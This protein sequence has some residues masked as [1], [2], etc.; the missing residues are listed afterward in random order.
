MIDIR[1]IRQSEGEAFLRHLCEVFRLDFNRAYDV[2]FT[3]PFFD[4]ARKWALFD[5]P[6]IISCLTTTPLE[7]GW[8]R[9]CGIAGVAT[10]ED[11]R[12]EGLAQLLLE[13]VLKESELHGEGSVLLFAHSTSVYE[14][15]GFEAIDRVIRAELKTGRE[16]IPK[17]LPD[18]QIEAKYNAW[19][20]AHPDRLRRDAR[21]WE[22]WHWNGREASPF[23]EGYL[24]SEAGLLR[25]AL[26]EEPVEQLPLPKG[27]EWFGTTFM[28]DQLGLPIDQIRVELYLMGYKVPGIPQMYLT[29]Q[30]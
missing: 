30:F 17:S 10:R 16:S 22:Y 19:A 7:F 25:E 27:S 9:A 28:A 12:R 5:G 14:R 21:R 4:L 2:F 23:Q 24:C 18:T 8:G 20:E 26:F 3:E 29:D 13:K 6:E 1:P 15:V 11:R